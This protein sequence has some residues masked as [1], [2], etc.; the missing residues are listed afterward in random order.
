MFFASF[1]KTLGLILIFFQFFFLFTSCIAFQKAVTTHLKVATDA[2][3]TTCC[4]SPGQCQCT[5]HA[6]A[7]GTLVF[8]M[9]QCHPLQ[10][11]LEGFSERWM[12]D[13]IALPYLYALGT[14]SWICLSPDYYCS[15]ITQPQPKPPCT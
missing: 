4:C 1:K 14:P 6:H 11:A 3:G 5:G 13:F 7:N 8:K 15:F 10:G 2:C 12:V 9:P